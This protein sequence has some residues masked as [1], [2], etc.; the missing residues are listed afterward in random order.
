MHVALLCPHV[1]TQ[2]WSGAWQ[3]SITD[4]ESSQII[5]SDVVKNAPPDTAT[6]AKCTSPWKRRQWVG[7]VRGETNLE[8]QL[9]PCAYYPTLK[10]CNHNGAIVIFS[11]GLR[12]EEHEG[13][14]PKTWV[15]PAPWGGVVL[16]GYDALIGSDEEKDNEKDKENDKAKVKYFCGLCRLV[17][18][19][20]YVLIFVRFGVVPCSACA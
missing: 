4:L 19:V 17:C 1:P 12:H 16:V 20:R 6:L 13:W 7:V 18:A 14:Y 11:A 15:L 5:I 9:V 10:S 2:C 3:F 8:G